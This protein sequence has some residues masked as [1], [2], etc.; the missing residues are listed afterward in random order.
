MIS[1][2]I[3]LLSSDLCKLCRTVGNYI[4]RSAECTLCMS[5]CSITVYSHVYTNSRIGGGGGGGGGGI[6]V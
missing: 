2:D 1:E 5:L 6:T 3:T 4:Y